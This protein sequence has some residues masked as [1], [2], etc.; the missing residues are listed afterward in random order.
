LFF[1][2]IIIVVVVVDF[3]IPIGI[4]ITIVVSIVHIFHYFVWVIVGAP[5]VGNLHDQRRGH[6]KR[7]FKRKPGISSSSSPNDG[8]L[9]SGNVLRPVF[10]FN[11]QDLKGNKTKVHGP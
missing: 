3:G 7:T 1:I 2:F 6:S 5:V 10:K 8:I 11:G 4:R 9:S